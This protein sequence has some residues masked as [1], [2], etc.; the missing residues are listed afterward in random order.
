MQSSDADPTAEYHVPYYVL[1]GLQLFLL[2][3]FVG[4]AYRDQLRGLTYL[5]YTQ[6]RPPEQYVPRAGEF[7]ATRTFTVNHNNLIHE[8]KAFI[9]TYYSTQSFYDWVSGFFVTNRSMQDRTKTMVK[10]LMKNKGLYR[11][12]ATNAS[13]SVTDQGFIEGFP[14]QGN[15]PIVYSWTLKGT[16]TLDLYRGGLHDTVT[17]DDQTAVLDQLLDGNLYVDSD[18]TTRV[19]G[20]HM[21]IGQTISTNQKMK[22]RRADDTLVVRHVKLQGINEYPVDSQQYNRIYDRI[23]Q[24]APEQPRPDRERIQ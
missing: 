9:E 4:F 12:D 7:I 10:Q 3:P 16:I 5:G 19:M 23:R 21:K 17:P 1:I 13:L 11:M 8:N 15:F 24:V 14:P 18:K 20:L 22:I 6:Q 2:L